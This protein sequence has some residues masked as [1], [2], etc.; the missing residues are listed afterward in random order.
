MFL[1]DWVCLAEFLPFL[2]SPQKVAWYYVISSEILSGRPSVRTSMRPSIRHHFI[3]S[4]PL[5]ISFEIFSRNFIPIR[6]SRRQCAEHMNHN[7]VLP[8]YGVITLWTLTIAIST[9][10]S[11]LLHNSDTV[12]DFSRNFTKIKSAIRRHVDHM[13]RYSGLPTF[14]VTA[15]WTLNITIPPCTHVRS[16]RWIPFEIFSWNLI[17]M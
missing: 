4:C 5:H 12:W 15:L 11:C 3:I 10:Y 6:S 7:S 9:M 13:N 2:C 1:G 14:V 17:Q 8:S 16:D